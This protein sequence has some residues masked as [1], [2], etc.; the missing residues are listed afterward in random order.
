M[1]KMDV[2]L[3][4]VCDVTDEITLNVG[5]F[6]I[7][8]KHSRCRANIG[9][10]TLIA[11]RRAEWFRIRRID[12]WIRDTFAL[13]EHPTQ[14]SS[15]MRVCTMDRLRNSLLFVYYKCCVFFLY[16]LQLGRSKAR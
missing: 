1:K 15:L 6:L 5:T 2:Q 13:H 10:E 9:S 4:G 8:F 16:W 12:E 14:R 11:E 3:P 7:L